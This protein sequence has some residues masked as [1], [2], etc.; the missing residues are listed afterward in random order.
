MAFLFFQTQAGVGF[1]A[2]RITFGLLHAELLKNTILMF[3]RILSILNPK[4]IKLQ[5]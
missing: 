1:R 4:I 2:K 3:F 5:F